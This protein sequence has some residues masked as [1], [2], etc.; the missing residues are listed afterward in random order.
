M[1][2]QKPDMKAREF[3]T[4]INDEIRRFFVRKT[5]VERNSMYPLLL[6]TSLVNVIVGAA[7]LLLGLR[8]ILELFAANQA[9]P[10][11]AWIYSS[12]HTL[13]E[14]FRGIFPTEAIGGGSVF[15]FS[16][17]FAILIYALIGYFLTSVLVWSDTTSAHRA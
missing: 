15:D 2:Y 7:E 8:F 14:P 10:F 12:S 13:L 1:A 5:F 17:L 3:L 16:T 4:K 6:L 9:T 11:V